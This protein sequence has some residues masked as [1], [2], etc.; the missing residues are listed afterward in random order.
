MLIEPPMALVMQQA[1]QRGQR[2]REQHGEGRAR[3]AEKDENHH[4]GQHQSDAGFFR[5]G[6]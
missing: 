6:S 5:A 4:T 2:N 1:Y 3:A